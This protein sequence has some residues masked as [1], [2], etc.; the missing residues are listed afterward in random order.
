MIKELLLIG[1]TY[2]WHVKH[3]DGN[4]NKDLSIIKDIIC[5]F[6]GLPFYSGNINF[7]SNEIR[8]IL[9]SQGDSE[10]FAEVLYKFLFKNITNDE[11]LYYIEDAI[12]YL[13]KHPYL[14]YPYILSI[15][16]LQEIDISVLDMLEHLISILGNTATKF[17]IILGTN[18]ERIPN[19]NQEKLTEFLNTLDYYNDDYRLCQNLYPLSYMEAKT[20]YVALLKNIENHEIL[21]NLL[22]NKAGTRPFDM[23]MQLKYMQEKHILSWQD[24]NSWFIRHFD[25]FDAFVNEVPIKSTDLIRKRVQTQLT[26]SK[27]YDAESYYQRCFKTL[28]KSLLLFRDNLPIEFL[29]FININEEIVTELM[30]SL[31]FRFD[32]DEP[33]IHFYHN[34]LYLYFLDQKIYMYDT[35]IA[36]KV[37]AWLENDFDYLIKNKDVI[38]LDCYIKLKRY[39]MAK[40]KGIE[41]LKNLLK[42]I[43]LQIQFRLL[44]YY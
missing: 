7:T 41:Y 12:I 1:E 36:N 22:I 34:N 9:K 6:I 25:S 33:E 44:N 17:I 21:L 31:F 20:F 28:I 2:N 30:N 3:Y 29:H 27:D 16:N 43:I 40:N 32:E 26:S 24:G 39:E 8:N 42:S 13:L 15:D 18:I 38:L 19:K 35:E 37:V 5:S 11:I 23:I 4:Y 14:D 10:D